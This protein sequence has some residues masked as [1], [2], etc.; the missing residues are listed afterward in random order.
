MLTIL[1]R[2]LIIY[3][4]LICIMR[5]MGKRQIGELE[6]T[7]LVTTLLISEIASLPITNQEIPISHALIPMV[8]LLILEVCSSIILIRFPNLK[9][10]VSASP[11]VIIQEG[12]LKQAALR[13]LRISI[14]E[15]IGEIRQQGFSELSQIDTAILEKNG[16]L[17]VLPKGR[18]ATPNAQQLGIKS[19][20]AGLMHII[21]ANDKISPRGLELIGRDSAWLAQ[22]LNKA[23][24]N[25]KEQFCITANRVGDLYCIP[26]E[27]L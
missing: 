11:T 21:Y 2:T 16:K 22:E 14:D 17:T 18:F 1:I 27:K 9:K 12:H 6:V 8:T 25:M 15:L 5:L 13:D 4:V 7:D 26:K 19:D 10:L 23:S 20:D 3:V 24:I